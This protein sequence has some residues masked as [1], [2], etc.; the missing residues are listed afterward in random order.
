MVFRGRG[1][2]KN[3]VQEAADLPA[4]PNYSR[5]EQLYESRRLNISNTKILHLDFADQWHD[6]DFV[7]INDGFIKILKITRMIQM[8][9]TSRISLIEISDPY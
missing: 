5:A 3:A 4:R 6:V 2:R 7:E 9:W 8:S 1:S